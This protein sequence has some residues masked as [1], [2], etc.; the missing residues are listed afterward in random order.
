MAN[1][2]WGEE[3]VEEEEEEKEEDKVSCGPSITRKKT[4]QKRRMKKM[5]NPA[6][7]QFLTPT[8]APAWDTIFKDPTLPSILD[9]G[10]AKGKFLRDLACSAQFHAAHGSMNFIGV[11]IFASLV[12]ECN[13]EAFKGSRCNLHYIASNMN[14]SCYSLAFPNLRIITIQFPDPWHEPRK[15]SR[16]VVN[17][18]LAQW[19]ASVATLREVFIVSDVLEL[20]REMRDIFLASGAFVLHPLHAQTDSPPGCAESWLQ[21]RPYFVPTERDLVCEILWRPVYRCLLERRRDTP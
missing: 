11:E 13:K 2:T 16:R 15:R 3:E 20:A 7:I 6:A 14:A 5:T 18:A 21:H 19:A 9:I 8:P 17:A 1:V 12:E 10:S 4:N